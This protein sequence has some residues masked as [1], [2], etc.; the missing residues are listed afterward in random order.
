MSWLRFLVPSLL[1][2]AAVLTGC[3][4]DRSSVTV[5]QPGRPGETGQV[6]PLDQVQ[7][8]DTDY[9]DADV[10]FMQGMIRHHAQAL[11]MTG[12]VAGRTESTGL[13]RFAKRIEVSQRDEMDLMVNW[14]RERMQQVPS[15][16]SGHAHSGGA[17]MPGMLT[18]AQLA[19]LRA[20]KGEQFDRLFYQY[21]IQHH[22]GALRMVE[23]LYTEKGGMEPEIDQF[24]THV[25]S[26]QRIEITRMRQL[27]AA[28]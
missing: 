13:P 6:L 17:L 3:S 7:P 14:L 24:A 27:L 11:E 4:D 2:G 16:D 22:T 9:T 23:Q 28:L 21:M 12:L 19:E 20:A 25:D 5:V 10:R 18:E 8:P 1:I 15:V 26:D